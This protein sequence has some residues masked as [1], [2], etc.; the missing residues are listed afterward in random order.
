MNNALKRFVVAAALSVG[1][2]LGG[3]AAVASGGRCISWFAEDGGY[4]DQYGQRDCFASGDD[5]E[6]HNFGGNC[7]CIV[8]GHAG[9]G[10]WCDGLM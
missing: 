6:F 2:S 1:L 4:C 5:P 7:G 8:N 9:A 3:G 10:D